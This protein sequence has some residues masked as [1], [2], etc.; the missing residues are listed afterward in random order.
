[1]KR[2]RSPV[3]V[4]TKSIK[5][6][7]SF[8]KQKPRRSFATYAMIIVPLLVIFTPS[9]QGYILS[10]WAGVGLPAL[11]SLSINAESMIVSV[12]AG[13]LLGRFL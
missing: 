12:G 3:T 6:G 1:M 4:R 10:A 8:K 5:R 9:L 13:W 7:S 11:P 2:R